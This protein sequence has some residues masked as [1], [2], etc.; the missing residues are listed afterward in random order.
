MAR[1][2]WVWVVVCAITACTA[3]SSVG[4]PRSAKEVASLAVA[5][6]RT[7]NATVIP[8]GSLIGST[9]VYA[10]SVNASGKVVGYE[11]FCGSPCW[12]PNAGSALVF[13]PIDSIAGFFAFP[14]LPS[15]WSRP[16]RAWSINDAGAI[17]GSGTGYPDRIVFVSQLQGGGTTFLPAPPIGSADA[18]NSLGLINNAAEVVGTSFVSSIEAHAILWEPA[19]GTYTVQELTVP[20]ATAAYVGGIAPNN[21]GTETI[22]V[23]AATVTSLYD[24]PWMWHNG[25]VTLLPLPPNWPNCLGAQPHD[26]TDGMLVVGEVCG[27]AGIW[28]SGTVALLSCPVAVSNSRANAVAVTSTG[29]TL[30]VGQCGLDPVVWSDDGVGGF[31]AEAL[32]LLNGDSEGEALD[33]SSGGFIAGTSSIPGF[34]HAAKWT[35]TPPPIDG[36]GD[37]VPNVIDNCP[38]V[39]NANQADFDQDGI[40]DVCD[41]NPGAN[42][43]LSF[44]QAPPPIFLNQTF[45]VNL[46]DADLGPGA[47]TGATLFIPATPAFR[48]VSAT[49]ATCGPVAGGLS[50]QL[51]PVAAGG[52][53]NFTMRFKA[54]LRGT[55]N[56]TLTLT[57]Q[58]TDTAPSNN[59]LLK[60]V[61]VQ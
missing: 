4:P 42:L 36:D 39:P 61:T 28:R 35:Y 22:V 46:R 19:P 12:S 1:R 47:S 60:T 53:L 57:G 17:A 38:A 55:F 16:Y 11:R 15:D 24:T 9:E 54:I 34:I 30:I 59:T 7:A 18:G 56:V 45:T 41:A 10:T 58:Q 32:P 29:R 52:Q 49:S 31:V 6:V 43:A 2:S 26:A 20:N 21:S 3:D 50:C 40:G 23:G 44:T 27:S 5:G 25:T 48:F 14:P 33:V 8:L 37:G 51:G 13:E